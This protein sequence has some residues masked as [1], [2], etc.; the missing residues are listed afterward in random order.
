MV[1]AIQKAMHHITMQ[2]HAGT[3][4]YDLHYEVVEIDSDY[5]K[6]KKFQSKSFRED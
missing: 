2:D 1:N 3:N 6:M 5:Q 4:R